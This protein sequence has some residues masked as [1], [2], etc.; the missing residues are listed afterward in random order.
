VAAS[1]RPPQKDEVLP[2]VPRRRTTIQRHARHI[3]SNGHSGRQS[4]RAGRIREREVEEYGSN[5]PARRT[6][7]LAAVAPGQ[8]EQNSRQHYYVRRQPKSV[9]SALHLLRTSASQ[10]LRCRRARELATSGSEERELQ[11]SVLLAEHPHL[12]T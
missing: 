11:G 3:T 1:C 9:A 5:W 8:A 4:M 7:R 10:R 6:I 2:R 12:P